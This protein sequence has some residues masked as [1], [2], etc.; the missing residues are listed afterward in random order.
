MKTVPFRF[1]LPCL[2][3][4][5]SSN[6][7]NAAQVGGPG[8]S[9]TTATAEYTISER[10]PHHRVWQHIDYET[11]QLGRVRSITNSFRELATGLHR[12]DSQGQWVDASETIA[13][14]PNGGAL[15]Q[16]GAHQVYFPGALFTD[17]VQVTT[18][19]AQVLVSRPLGLS[20]SD[21]NQTLL[22]A[23]LAQGPTGQLLPSGN[24]VIYTN[25]CTGCRLDLLCTYTKAGF[26]SDLVI[27]EQLPDPATLGFTNSSSLMLQWWTEFF[28]PPLPS[29]TQV[30]LADSS[31]DDSVL[32]FGAMQMTR[33]SAY[34]VGGDNAVA[35]K[36]P[37]TKQ[38]TVIE[39]RTFLVEEVPFAAVASR[40]QGLPPHTASIQKSSSSLFAGRP[41]AVVPLPRIPRESGRTG[42]APTSAQS[43]SLSAAGKM[44][45]PPLRLPKHGTESIGVAATERRGEPGFA[46]DYDLHGSF[47]N[48]TFQSDTTYYI[49]G[50]VNLSGVTTIEG[51]TV[52][53]FTNT[54]ASTIVVGPGIVWMTAPYRQAIFTSKD[55]NSVG[56]AIGAS[57]GNPSAHYYSSTALNA[58]ASTNGPAVSGARFSYL[59]NAVSCGTANTILNAQFVQCYSVIDNANGTFNLRNVLGYQIGGFQNENCLNGLGE[60]ICDGITLA[61]ENCTFHI[62]TNF[63]GNPGGSPVALTNCILARV[64]NTAPFGI[65]STN[66]TVM[67]NDDTGL[68]Q[69]AVAGAHYLAD[70]SP[71]RNAGTTNI[72]SSLIASLRQKTTYP[73]IVY[74]NVIFAADTVFFPQA[75][76]D[77]D[78]IDLGWHYD[79]LDWA[80]AVVQVTNSTLQLLPGT[81]LGTYGTDGL[82]LYSGANMVS[83]GSPTALNRIV[84]YNMVQEH[85]NTNADPIGPSMYGKAVVGPSAVQ[86]TFRFTDWSAPA[87]DNYHFKSN[88]QATDVS[89][90]DCQ[91]HG[92]QFLQNMPNLYLTNNLFE[93]VNTTI[94]DSEIGIDVSPV[95]RNCLFFGGQLTI[96]H[97]NSDTWL[98][99]DNLFDQTIIAQDGDVDNAYAG[100]TPGTTHL[101]VT[102][103]H[104]VVASLSYKAGPLGNY[105]QPTSSAFINVGSVSNAGLVGLYHYTVTTNLVSGSEIAETNG[106]VDI[107]FHYV[108]VDSAGNPLDYDLDGIPDYLED[109]NGNG[110]LDSGETDWQSASD[111]GL[112]VVITRP[113]NN[114]VIP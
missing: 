101:T 111:A 41:S 72:N 85:A 9:N 17:A 89:C 69:T 96:T 104:D 5:L 80:L 112:R 45:L 82:A 26:E 48:Y 94:D 75:Q 113:K 107:G 31:E 3:A 49:S 1:L 73:P 4:V 60:N 110:L 18:P 42:P 66:S 6:C 25:I 16:S 47:T 2:L 86:A 10:G 37:V 63:V 65:L 13:I 54:P 81:A 76:R 11:N 20:F 93:R 77:T 83:V 64:T 53:K 30:T 62:I 15:A 32:D 50:T 90:T 92:G 79:P 88:G 28:N 40:L 57:T 97:W 24:Q 109:A 99:R 106:I 102:N 84:R 67:L 56:T 71:Y 46:I 36:I 38:W 34:L 27:R 55:D 44:G 70:S 68:F 105:Y 98:F 43:K 22:I 103:A 58:S 12:K 51:G 95:V 52:I 74:S 108:A 39:G 114:S 21:Q 61:A 29:K 7:A 87:Q 14:Q 100:Y 91:F 35:A 59:S 78:A 23:P 33:G 8:D 19:D